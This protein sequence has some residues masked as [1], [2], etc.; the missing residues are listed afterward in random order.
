M[1]YFEAF[2]ESGFYSAFMTTYAFG[3]QAFED[4]P[5]PKLRA[6]GC[7]NIV[8]LADRQMTN[9]SFAEY[10]PP[11]FAGS[12]YHLIKVD[13]PG[14]FHP[15]I[16]MLVGP[17]KG[18]LMIGSANLTALG[19]GG[20]KELV[21]NIIYNPEM[22]DHARL[23]AAVITYIRRYVPADDTW[24]VTALQRAMRRAPWLR[25]AIEAPTTEIDTEND[26]AILL[27]R[28]EIT[29]L[30]QIVRQIGSDPIER[31]VVVSPYWDVKLEGLA[32]LWS[33]LGAPPTDLLIESTTTGFP[34]SELD[35][36]SD[37]GLFDV[38]PSASN[39]FVHAKLL[40]AQ[41]Q[42]WDHVIS[43]SMNCTFP[44][45]MGPSAPRG[46]AEAGIY[47]RVD[48]GT[49]LEALG[50]AAYRDTPI[51]P[52][53]VADMTL[54]ATT[55]HDEGKFVDGGALTI[56]AG[57]LSWSPPAHNP[58]RLPV[59][60][61]LRDRDEVPLGREIELADSDKRNWALE[62]DDVR[63]KSALIF[64]SDAT[65]SAPVQVTD[66][67]ILAFATLP[68]LRGKKKP[69][70]D[71]LAELMNED[72]IL[73]ETL[74]Q[75]EALEIEEE[76]AGEGALAKT[77]AL[78]L[79]IAAPQSYQVASYEEFVRARTLSHARG[80]L[81]GNFLN[82]RQD[83]AANTLSACLNR[84]IGL[85]SADLGEA[86]DKDIHALAAID[87][88]TTEP[89]APADVERRNAPDDDLPRVRATNAQSLATAKKMQEAVTA[90]EGRCKSLKGKSIGTA[91]LV[92][93]RALLQIILTHSQ[94]IHGKSTTAQTL[95][96]Y[97][98]D[99][100]DWPRLIG[101]LLKQHFGTSRALQQLQ[102]EQDEAEQKR[103][104]E[105][106]ALAG[107]A[108]RA[109]VQAVKANP[110][111]M[112]LRGPLERLAITLQSQVL[113]ILGD[114]AEDRQYFAQLHAKLDE[115]FSARLGLNVSKMN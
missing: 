85:V 39:R 28:P 69:L 88:R 92:R 61:M 78:S 24:F 113:L 68:P 13:A 70:S 108:A 6:A 57:R 100:H 52:S 65:T 81:A 11:R 60:M 106:L 23:F 48:R 8:V 72:L 33:A 111:A 37:I 97:T 41:G 103:V 43:G 104:M 7:R 109:A 110:K 94:A 112:E 50:L 54:T 22:P 17:K 4:V 18:R 67:D 31:L 87:F 59:S 47:K 19:L 45:L 77:A 105:Y 30:D 2:A 99:G 35:R 96:V 80:G 63:P 79:T 38:D 56:Q 3:A 115:R 62:L 84:L 46:N 73:I 91:E 12:S 44:A 51:Q 26:I 107:W 21:A 86:E 114:V 29:I 101:R 58:L 90:F 93:L 76:A 64:F 42:S 74:N 32:R 27:D 82:G 66:L 40:V 25:N 10:G 20:N 89:V 102:V 36:F 71:I 95:P 14:A 15:K 53:S 83:S 1:R 5:F 9:Q 49:A 98:K 34:K 55:T 16:T 75:L